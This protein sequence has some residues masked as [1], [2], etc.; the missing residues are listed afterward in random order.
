M[1][2][3]TGASGQLGHKVIEK[4]ITKVAANQVVAAVRDPSKAQDLAK[5]GVV[6]RL[7]DYD[8]PETIKEALAA[9]DRVLL[10]SSNDLGR[11]FEQHKRVVDAAKAAGVQLLAYTSLL[12]ADTSKMV[13]AQEHRLTEAYIKASALPYS[14]LRNGW[15][16][17][18]HSEH[19]KAAVD[20]GAVVGSAGAGRFASATRADYAEAAVAVLTGEHPRNRIYELSGD[21]A[22][23]LAELA[24][25]ITRHSK[26]PV[27]YTD[28]PETAY[29]KML[30]GFGMPKPMAQMLSDS[31]AWAAKGALQPAGDDLHTLIGRATTPWQ[32][33]IRQAMTR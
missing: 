3:I 2:L 27:V 7:L 24:A 30:L 17:E 28:M 20:H 15:Y 13:L 9:V 32:N 21:T 14:V 23:T 10:I 11:R 25:E 6:V 12:H 5:M 29:Q 8:K 16:V 22:F 26:T 19:I 4:L 1:Y 18:N 31:D 33:V